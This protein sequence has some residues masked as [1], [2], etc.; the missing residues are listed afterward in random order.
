MK[1]LAAVDF[2]TAT[3]AVRADPSTYNDICQTNKEAMVRWI[4]EY[5]SRLSELRILVEQ[6]GPDLLAAFTSAQEE[7]AKWLVTR[8]EDMSELPPLPSSQ[9]TGGALRQ[10]FLGGM[11]RERP[12][13]GEKKDNK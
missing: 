10:M 13:P 9:G 2:E 11:G 6:G 1:R 4:D 5:M 8:D 7:R 12:L 3:A